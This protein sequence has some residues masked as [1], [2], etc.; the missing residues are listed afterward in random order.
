VAFV[1]FCSRLI[2]A[3]GRTTLL[4]ISTRYLFLHSP[5]AAYIDLIDFGAHAREIYGI[6]ETYGAH[7]ESIEW[8]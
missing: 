2:F 6:Y 7:V 5:V 3:R 4:Y 1:R 8:T